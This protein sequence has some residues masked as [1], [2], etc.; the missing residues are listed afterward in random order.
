MDDSVDVNSIDKVYPSVLGYGL[1]PIKVGLL[2][3]FTGPIKAL[4]LTLVY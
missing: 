3:L 2:G 4:E 1:L